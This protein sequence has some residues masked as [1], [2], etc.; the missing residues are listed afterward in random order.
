MSR[1]PS[2]PAAEQ[3]KPLNP[4]EK[5][6][7]DREFL[8]GFQFIFASMQKPEGLPQITDVVLDKV[9]AALEGGVAWVVHRCGGLALLLCSLSRQ[10]W[11]FPAVLGVPLQPLQ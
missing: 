4:E 2:A 5:K 10:S 3:W 7:Y 8:L 1:S 11:D 9:G 6:R